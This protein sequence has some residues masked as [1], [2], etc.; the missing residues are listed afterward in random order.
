MKTLFAT[1]ALAM[2]LASAAQAAPSTQTNGK[3]PQWIA[4]VFQSNNG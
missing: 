4:K 3:T 1:L 2:A